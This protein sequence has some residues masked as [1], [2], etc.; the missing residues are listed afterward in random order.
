MPQTD[1]STSPERLTT[2]SGVAFVRTPD[3]RFDGLP[4]WPYEPRYVEIDGLRQA[5]VDQGPADAHP[6]LL[7]H[8][9]PS[10]GYLYRL[11]IPVL[12]EAGYRVVAMDHLGMGR[13]D[14]PLDPEFY[15]FD[16]HADRLRRFV[17]ELELQEATLFAQDWGSVLAMWTVAH[18]LSL[19]SR[20]AIGN[21]GFPPNAP[22][23]RLP[24]A[25]NPLVVAFG[26]MLESMPAQQ[27]RFFDDDGNIDM[28]ALGG[29]LMPDADAIADSAQY[30]DTM[31]GVMFAQWAGYAGNSESFRPSVFVEALTYRDL[32]AEA[33]AGYDAPFPTREYL[34]G[35]RSFPRCLSDL[36]GRTAEPKEALKG[37][38]KPV[39]TIFGRND[40]GLLSPESDDQPW[41]I[42]NMPGAAGQDHHGYPDASHFLQEDKGKDIARRL[43]AFIEGSP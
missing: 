10:W 29:N 35:P 41:I 7:L 28:A 15:S 4:A 43:L 1:L 25:D 39:L 23:F 18:D 40:P 6:I 17:D 19:F 27:P 22:S 3:S 14:K 9:Q 30:S 34:A 8:G 11:M 32:G 36:H 33:R 21:G 31:D 13:S 37:Y 5:Y 12:V 2:A 26:Q 38:R 20:I 42:E 16:L 24:P